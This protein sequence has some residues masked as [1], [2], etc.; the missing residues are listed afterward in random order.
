MKAHSGPGYVYQMYDKRGRLLY[1]GSTISP[2]TRPTAHQDKDWWHLVAEWTVTV[3]PTRAAAVAAEADL[4]ASMN[5]PC[6]TTLRGRNAGPK[7][8]TRG[9][10]VRSNAALSAVYADARLRALEAERWAAGRLQGL[11]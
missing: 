3:Y 10:P 6:N 7:H 4:I 1:I 5:P 11:S 2:A 9:G 8:T